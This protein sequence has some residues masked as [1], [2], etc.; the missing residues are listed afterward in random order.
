MKQVPYCGSTVLELPVNLIV[1]W[2][3]LL[4]TVHVNMLFVVSSVFCVLFV[5][6]CILL[7]PGVNP[8]AVK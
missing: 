2:R 8:T 5:C 6:K 7:L 3:V 1:I 4:G